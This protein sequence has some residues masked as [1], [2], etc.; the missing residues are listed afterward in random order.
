MERGDRYIVT[1]GT[2]TDAN[3]LEDK[4]NAYIVSLFMC[5]TPWVSPWRT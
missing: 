3:M 5:E 2:I 1:P 4:K